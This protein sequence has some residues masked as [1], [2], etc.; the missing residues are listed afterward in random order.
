VRVQNR[1][2]TRNTHEFGDPVDD[3]IDYKRDT[4]L[5][6]ENDAKGRKRPRQLVQSLSKQTANI[7]QKPDLKRKGNCSEDPCVRTSKAKLKPKFKS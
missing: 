2:R 6:E 1:G 3:S 5:T 4:V 7:I